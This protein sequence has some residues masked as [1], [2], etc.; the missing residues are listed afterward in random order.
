MRGSIQRFLASSVV[1]F[2]WLAAASSA[3]TV[4]PEALVEGFVRA[5]NAHDMKAFGNLFTEGADW[6]S[7]AGLR[8]KSRAKIQAEHEEAHATWAKTTTLASTGTEVRLVCPDV[9]VLHFNWELNSQ[10]DPEGKPRAPRRGIITIVAVKQADGWRIGAGQNTNA[11][12]P[13]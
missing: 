10:P 2:V 1:F 3:Q 9:A 6:V 7:V 12:P 11:L 5:W 4:G 13:R 8:V